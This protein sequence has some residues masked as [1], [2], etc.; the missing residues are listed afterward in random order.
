MGQMIAVA[1]SPSALSPVSC[2][3]IIGDAIDCE[4]YP[5][6]MGT[7]A[8][9]NTTS[10]VDHQAYSYSKTVAEKAA[11]DM[12][13]GQQ[14]WDLVVIN[15]S[16]VLGPGLNA[17]ATS[18]SFNLFKQ[19]GN[20]KMKSGVPD[21]AIGMIDLRD[22]AIAHYNAG[23]TPEA[24]GRNIISADNSDSLTLGKTLRQH[25]GDAYPFPQ[26][27]LPKFMVWLMA[28]LVGFKRKMIKL[29]VGHKWQVDNSK[30]KRELRMSYRPMQ[31]TVIDFFQQMI[32]TGK[33]RPKG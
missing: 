16:L 28:P 25:Y 2:A 15:P 4:A 11:W 5:N 29:N 3:A 27:N 32:D 30:G 1:P 22:L 6:G 7:E 8:Q 21:F 18:E 31:Q 12:V 23:F 24:N 17:D 9:W 26:K 19:L 13:K 14:R 20:G 33:V 10:S